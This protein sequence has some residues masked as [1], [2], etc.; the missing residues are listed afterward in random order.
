MNLRVQEL[1]GHGMARD[2]HFVEVLIVT[3]P[4]GFLFASGRFTRFGGRGETSQS[5]K[6]K[7]KSDH[8]VI[9]RQTDYTWL[10]TF[11]IRG[12][13]DIHFIFIIKILIRVD[14]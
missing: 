12:I 4:I 13:L 7:I 5:V 8:V 11:G 10:F 2:L 14:A 6:N 3:E 1:I 9:K